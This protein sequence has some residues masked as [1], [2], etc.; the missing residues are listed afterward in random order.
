M[1]RVQLSASPAGTIEVS[2]PL[3]VL[4]R[5]SLVVF[6]ALGRQAAVLV[7][8][9]KDAETYSVSFDGSKL[10]SGIYFAR[11]TSGGKSQMRKLML[12]K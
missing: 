3:S 8:D 7:N 12:V 6:D 11:L 2:Y 1:N 4:G 9:V 10:S 5:T